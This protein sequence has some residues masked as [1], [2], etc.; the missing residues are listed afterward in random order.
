MIPAFESV[1]LGRN[2]VVDRDSRFPGRPNWRAPLGAVW[3]G[4]MRPS[5]GADGAAPSSR[6]ASYRASEAET[7]TVY[8]NPA[9]TSTGEGLATFGYAL[10][11]GSTWTGGSLDC[12]C[13][14][15]SKLRTLTRDDLTISESGKQSP[16]V[17]ATGPGLTLVGTD[18]TLGWRR[19]G[20]DRRS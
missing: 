18:D 10:R 8:A 3:N 13:G 19:V 6:S 7:Q 2:D 11:R 17:S 20:N 5:D 14:Q 12:T 15:T 16:A 4:V 9:D 1:D